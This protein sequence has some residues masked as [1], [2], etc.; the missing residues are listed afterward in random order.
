M[1]NVD[2]FLFEDEAMAEAARKE[3]EGIRFIKERTALDNPEIVLK[4]Y[5]K[6]LQE[7]LFVTPIGVRFLIELQNILLA[8]TYIPRE[9]IPPIPMPEYHAPVVEEPKAPVKKMV[10]QIDNK[11]GGEYKKPFFV[12]LFFA[13]VF[14]LS[15]IGMF[16]VAEISGNNVNILNYK[17]A[18]IDEYAGW[19]EELDEKEAELNA[20]E[21]ELEAREAGLTN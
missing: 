13:I 20:W 9:D 3:E 21:K 14:G 8:S 1:Y 7:E 6:L 19:A 2:G 10:E 11:V 4:L 16:V 12:A 18:L 5:T 17:E 15:V